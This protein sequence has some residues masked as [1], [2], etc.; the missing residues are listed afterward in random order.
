MLDN[1][2]GFPEFPD[3]GPFHIK[4]RLTLSDPSISVHCKSF[5]LI[6]VIGLR[7]SRLRHRLWLG[8]SFWY[9]IDEDGNPWRM[10]GWY[11]EFI[12]LGTPM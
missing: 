1:D 11:L 10:R 2:A 7:E 4:D 8:E 6:N 5:F 12:M 9:G 3:E